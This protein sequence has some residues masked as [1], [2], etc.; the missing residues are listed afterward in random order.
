MSAARSGAASVSAADAIGYVPPPESAGGWRTIE[1]PGDAGIDAQKLD[2]MMQ[3]QLL[4]NGGDSWSAVIIRYGHIVGE[5][6]TFNIN[7]PSRFDIWSATKSFTSTA[8][9][10]LIDDSRAGR[11]GRRIDLDTAVYDLLAMARPLSDP[12]KQQITI[13]HLLTMT[14]GI[15]GESLGLLGL[16]PARGA[17]PFETA[18]GL[19]DNR[20]GNSAATLAASPGTRWDYSDAGFAHLGLAFKQASGEELEAFLRRRVFTAIGIENLSWDVQGGSGFMGPHTNAHTGIHVSA[21]ELA[22]FGYLYM[23]KGRWGHAQVVPEWWVDKATQPSQRLNSHY[24]QAI[25]TNSE[26]TLWPDVPRDAFGF[27]GY[28]FSACYVVPS[29]DLVAVRIGTGPASWDNRSFISAAVDTI[30]G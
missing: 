10:L 22:R 20:F 3:S 29:L 14:S 26:G 23:R 19:A 9:G 13:E 30:R 24:G 5:Q 8:Y 15:A 12:R 21:R 6:H 16:S 1:A 4:I 11:L 27:L 25:W 2:R 28:R 7:I 18:L 17:G